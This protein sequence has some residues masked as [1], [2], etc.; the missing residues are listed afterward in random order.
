MFWTWMYA[1]F[2]SVAK[3][4]LHTKGAQQTDKSVLF[5]KQQLLVSEINPI[6]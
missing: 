2:A 5:F 4:S 3:F 1:R 6:W